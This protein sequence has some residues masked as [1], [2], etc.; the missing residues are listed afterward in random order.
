MVNATAAGRASTSGQRSGGS[1]E[2]GDSMISRRAFVA[3]GAA[4]LLTA[5][6][7]AAAQ[8][9]GQPYRIGVLGTAPRGST[10]PTHLWK[11]FVQSLRELGYVEGQNFVIEHRYGPDGQ[12]DQLLAVAA[13]LVRLKVDIIVATG[14][15]T[16][17]AAK[18]A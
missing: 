4:G 2:R 3:V 13:E 11:A 6:L 10:G 14:T 15:L 18:A 12:P 7:A 8:Q 5:P 17:H 9:R 1:A 16:P